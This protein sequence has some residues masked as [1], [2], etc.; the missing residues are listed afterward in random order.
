VTEQL[1]LDRFRDLV[2]RD[3]DLEARLARIEGAE[4]FVGE[5]L[6]VAAAHGIALDQAELAPALERD[7]IG[8][9]RAV[10]VAPSDHWPSR[11]WLPVAIVQTNAGLAVDWA[12]FAGAPLTESFFGASARIA[13]ARPFNSLFR[14]QT[15]LAEFISAQEQRPA[16]DG[17][18]FH[19]SRCGSTLV[20]QMLAALPDTICVSEAQPLDEAIH[21]GDPGLVRAMIA[22]LGRRG[23]QNDRLFFKL[24][25]WHALAIADLA[26]LFPDTPWL[27]LFRE[28][29]EIL[30]SH[31]AMP[32]AEMMPDPYWLRMFRLDPASSYGPDH[33]ARVLARIAE[34]AT[35]V[36]GKGGLFL[37]YA[38][39][40]GAVT[41]ALLP[42]FGLAGGPAE[43]EAMA[44]A[45]RLD[46][47]RPDRSF[48]ADKQA[49]RSAVT[50]EIEAAARDHL[51]SPFRRLE[52]LAARH[53]PACEDELL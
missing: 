42:H 19:W 28:P 40:P 9:S 30:V 5:A 17:L 33:V 24:N 39:L 14:W 3:P 13:L 41:E 22:A 2:L 47:K 4:A 15:P 16:P 21:I 26:G 37:D 36:G 48:V 32:A 12:H 20:S 29:V 18:V 50:P 49:K 23:K 10:A 8:L 45:T 1:A 51:A 34:A 35:G 52:E 25:C 27:F 11:E 46:A 6:G 7:P 53:S 31:A 43:R 44:A 38:E